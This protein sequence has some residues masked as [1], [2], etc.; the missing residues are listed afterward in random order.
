MTVYTLTIPQNAWDSA[1]FPHLIKLKQALEENK[2][3]KKI[4][5]SFSETI[6]IEPQ[7]ILSLAL[8]LDK[9]ATQG[10]ALDVNLGDL[11]TAERH[12]F[13]RFLGSQGFIS[14]LPNQTCFFHE[15]QSDLL[16]EIETEDLTHKL[17]SLGTASFIPDQDLLNAQI[18]DLTNFQ[19]DNDLITLVVSDLMREMESR[20]GEYSFVTSLKKRELVFQKLKT[21]L[22]ETI[23]NVSDHTSD[24]LGLCK[25]AVFG[26]I[27]QGVPN[28]INRSASWHRAFYAEYQNAISLQSLGFSKQQE[29]IELFIC[30]VGNGILSH[31]DSWQTSNLP[32]V[33][34]A[35]LSKKISGAQP[36]FNIAPL[37]FIEPIS[38]FEERSE[39][40]RTSITGL[41][42]IGKVLRYGGA[43]IRI[44]DGIESIGCKFPW[45]NETKPSGW[46]NKNVNENRDD[47]NRLGT[48]VSLSLQPFGEIER[49][50]SPH[51][52]PPSNA[53]K[54]EILTKLAFG[55]KPNSQSICMFD[56][57]FKSKIRPDKTDIMEAIKEHIGEVFR[58]FIRLPKRA[59]KQ[60]FAEWV[61]IVL[62]LS[63]DKGKNVSI[64]FVDCEAHDAEMYSDFLEAMKLPFPGM[65][66]ITLITRKFE[67]ATYLKPDGKRITY[68]RQGTKDF[69]NGKNKSTKIL[70]VASILRYMDSVVF[71]SQGET[72]PIEDVYYP[73]E[74]IW[75]ASSDINPEIKFFGYLD[76]QSAILDSFRF[77]TCRRVLL[78]YL[79]LL[80]DPNLVITDNLVGELYSVA[81]REHERSKSI[82]DT[83]TRDLFL[84]SV[85]ISGDTL[86][87]EHS[88]GE[89]RNRDF[90]SFLVR[91]K[92]SGSERIGSLLLW[93]PPKMPSLSGVYKRVTGTPY[94]SKEGDYFTSIN[95]YEVDSE[96]NVRSLYTRSPE[97][98]YQDF[99]RHDSLS[100][101]HF[102]GS[103]NHELIH[104]DTAGLLLKA[105]AGNEDL[106]KWL[107]S[108]LRE[109]VEDKG[110]NW[111]YLFPSHT[112]NNQL[113]RLL[114]DY[115]AEQ[116]VIKKNFFI[117]SFLR[118][119]INEPFLFSPQ[120]EER[121]RSVF[122]SSEKP[123]KA[124]I[125][126]F[127]GVTGRTH[128]QI[129]QF[130]QHCSIQET[131]KSTVVKTTVVLDRSGLPIRNAVMRLFFAR[132]NR[133]WRWDV[134]RL[135]PPQSCSLCSA[136][137][138]LDKSISG[139]IPRKGLKRVTDV[140]RK[141]WLLG[142]GNSNHQVRK[143]TENINVDYNL[144]F[145]VIFVKDKWVSRYVHHTSIEPLIANIIELT[146]LTHRSDIALKWEVKPEA[147]LEA[148]LL[149]LASTLVSFRNQFNSREQIKYYSAIIRVLWKVKKN[150]AASSLACLLL[151]DMDT[152]ILSELLATLIVPKIKSDPIE[153]EDFS[154]AL[155]LLAK[156][157]LSLLIDEKPNT[158]LK[159]NLRKCG[160][161]DGYFNY[162]SDFFDSVGWSNG[163]WHYQSLRKSIIKFETLDP[164]LINESI[165]QEVYASVEV[166]RSISF[167]LE[168][169]GDHLQMAEIQL[170]LRP[171]NDA[172]QLQCLASELNAAAI[173]QSKNDLSIT[174]KKVH[175]SLFGASGTNKAIMKKYRDA[176]L[177]SIKS[178]AAD[179]AILGDAIEQ[180]TQNWEAYLREKE[181]GYRNWSPKDTSKPKIPVIFQAESS[182]WDFNGFVYFD[183]NVVGA[184]TDTLQN[185][186]YSNRAINCPWGKANPYKADA[187]W[188]IT[189]EE[190][191]ITIHFA[192]GVR[193]NAPISVSSKKI[194]ET[195]ETCG[196]KVHAP[197]VVGKV[198]YTR[199]T[200][201]LKRIEDV[202]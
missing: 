70:E 90:I 180:F 158:V 22:S 166:L 33:I 182:E 7:S 101:G 52:L 91:E 61:Q 103:T 12:E 119:R 116:L 122:A 125:V 99:H 115:Y 58:A 62:S 13:L 87:K 121:I 69:S 85:V 129:S 55:E 37:L 156:Q 47:L 149:I 202:Q 188:K 165:W 88:I 127:T 142:G 56:R 152:K 105:E 161:L 35:K 57:R 31:S 197:E 39:N 68:S 38:R 54:L 78:R 82:T 179:V 26:R 145:G 117:I 81:K 110:Y 16:K 195:I 2:I 6:W 177:F 144:K 200:L 159:G 143:D 139:S 163:T 21:F 86:L 132:N 136:L 66:R 120:I 193:T 167:K 199:I 147:S 29:W 171:A 173:N 75:R 181:V 45:G 194:F 104:L 59:S 164:N 53:V 5:V 191:T 24:D 41:Q 148:K 168:A 146:R 184:I 178:G 27:R 183:K 36:L 64:F 123:V 201:P 176:L 128:R 97:Q 40:F 4:S 140:W 185:I 113:V 51:F 25:L 80:D 43:H 130:V 134:P 42:A 77:Q 169:I 9:A 187:W 196:A 11:K 19:N 32:K 174:S 106:W 150:S 155:F 30:D 1:C 190:S 192:N 108:K 84:G 124:M 138:A 44:C 131:Q 160:F 114:S 63:E 46:H 79:K 17:N 111:I 92:T 141:T 175:G 96:S 94:I 20:S 28:D 74:C 8:L 10:I 153:S 65:G 71:W 133:Y 107:I 83:N 48:F 95:R 135:G 60:D 189:A 126:D 109:T 18:I 170:D 23:Q 154:V 112:S 73:V 34:K 50:K 93:A 198:C 89:E 3:I 102:E 14:C 15:N 67:T 151:I 162:V 98:T 118:S 186:S 72:I 76:F 137:L 172:E 49:T 100:L 157:S